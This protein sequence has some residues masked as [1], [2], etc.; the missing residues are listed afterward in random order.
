MLLSE[1]ASSLALSAW[2]CQAAVPSV[3]AVVGQ[4]CEGRWACS[5]RVPRLGCGREVGR[6][7]SCATGVEQCCQHILPSVLL[8]G[9]ECPHGTPAPRRGGI[10]APGQLGWGGV[11]VLLKHEVTGKQEEQEEQEEQ[12]LASAGRRLSV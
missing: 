8:P 9:A 1:S 3:C 4:R 2:Q 6:P 5:L 11:K 10:G 12:A 7:W